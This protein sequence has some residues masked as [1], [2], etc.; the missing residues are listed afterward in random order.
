MK[1]LKALLTIIFFSGIIMTNINCA[2]GPEVEVSELYQ[3]G[4]PLIAFR[5]ELKAGSVNDPSGK[6]GLDAL[7]A[8]T[9]GEGGTKELT[10][11]QV[12]DKLYPW[13][14]SITPQADKEVTIFIGEVHIDHLEEYY[15]IFTDLLFNPRFDESDFTRNKDLLVSQLEN[16]LRGTDDE[17]LGK[18]ALN[19]FMYENHPYRAT[20]VGTVQ[21]L[22]SITLDDVKSYYR[23]VYTRDNIKIGIAGG[24]PKSLID[25]IKKDFNK[26]PSGILNEVKLP[27]PAQINNLEIM[28]VEKPARGTAISMGF[29][30]SI[31]RKDKDF[32]ALML[33]N[34]YLGEHRTFNG[35]LMNRLRGDRGLNY[36]DYSYIEHWVQEGGSTFQLPNTPRHQQYFSI[37]IRPVEPEKAHFAIRNALY[38]LNRLVEKGLTEEQFE[39]TRKYLINYSKLWV[40]TSSRRLGYQMDSEFYGTE[41][42]IDKI[43]KELDLLKLADVNNV[44]KKYLNA[45]NLKIAVVCSDAK[46]LQEAMFNNAPSPIKYSSPV[47]QNILDEDKIIEIF[48]LQINKE[49]SRIVPVKELFEK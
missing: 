9:I 11:Q 42:F 4:S 37:W 22:K 12:L 2:K 19:V 10:Y 15:K 45:A 25:R 43:E 8:L 5:V 48:P 20:E 38:E 30:L 44:I 29:P 17:N 3:P 16:T 27:E 41:F 23:Q 34:S 21:G 18:E 35:V 6:E 1:N 36:G 49:K 47:S 24:Y 33:V 39:S 13:A 40:Q 28:F 7:T 31:T 14:A 46:S 32:Y 26:L